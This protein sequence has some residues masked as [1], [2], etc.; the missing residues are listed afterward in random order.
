MRFRSWSYRFAE[1]VMNSKFSLKQEIEEII[2]AVDLDLSE[3]SRP[4]LN[5]EFEK[6]FLERDWEKEPQVFEGP[7]DPQAK[8]DFLKDRVGVEVAFTHSS[9][10]GIDLLKFQTLSYSYLDRI[11]VGVYIMVTKDYRRKLIKEYDQPWS[12][13]L[14]YEKVQDYL[15]HF[16]SAIQVPIWIIG[17]EE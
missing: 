16:R 12:G 3:L 4:R 2:R 8:I 13:S 15:P 11:D 10:I 1:E 9:F 6:E 14:T 5:K 7:A 17:L